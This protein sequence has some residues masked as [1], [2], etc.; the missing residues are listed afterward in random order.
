MDVLG[1]L[2]DLSRL[3]GGKTRSI[4]AENPDGAPGGGGK[5]LPEK[6]GPAS[7]LGRGWKARPCVTLPPASVVQLADISGPG[8]ITH[9]WMTADPGAYQT[10]LLRCFWEN[11]VRASV[12]V[13]LGDFFANGGGE[14]Y[15]VHS[16][17]VVVNPSGGF[18]SYWP[19]PF[20]TRCRIEIEN[21]STTPIEQFYY[22]ISFECREMPSDAAYFHAVWRRSATSLEKPE[23][24]ILDELSGRGHYVGTFLTW[25]QRSEGWWGE[26][27]VKFFIDDDREYPTICG[28]G[29]EDYFGGAW[30]FGKTYSTLFLGYPFASVE[31]PFPRH[32]LY[33]WH[34]PDPVR[35]EKKLRVTIQALGWFPHGKFKPLCDEIS[36]VA[37]WYQTEPHHPFIPIER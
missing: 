12:E 18:N 4:S 24:V 14:R 31:G 37:Y 20:R 21:R 27:E 34:I 7:E 13:P 32:C 8:V 3:S 30:C 19:M 25:L 9:I 2:H 33:R 28:T 11:E 22:Q 29:R 10:C 26:G 5:A 1:S 36:S 16:L 15:N 23:H 35:F 6:D 17:P